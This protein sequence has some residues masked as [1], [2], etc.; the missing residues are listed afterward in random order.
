MCLHSQTQCSTNHNKGSVAGRAS[1]ALRQRFACRNFVG[2]VYT[3]STP[4]GSEISRNGRREVELQCLSWSSRELSS[5]AKMAQSHPKLCESHAFLLLHQPGLRCG[6]PLGREHDHRQ[7]GSFQQRNLKEGLSWQLLLSTKQMCK[8][9]L[10]SQRG[11]WV[12][13]H[14]IHYRGDR[15]C[16]GNP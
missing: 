15:Y 13:W 14:V 3:T 2:G 11:L 4:R 7:G 6:L 5:G 9:V 16:M 10:H 8:W 12:A 1:P